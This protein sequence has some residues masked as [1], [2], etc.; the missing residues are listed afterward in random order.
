MLMPRCSP[1]A[2]AKGSG[3]ILDTVEP[4]T[5]KIAAIQVAARACQKPDRHVHRTHRV[6]MSRTAREL[7]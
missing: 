4:A 3:A 7:M 6:H 2:A 5:W 1:I